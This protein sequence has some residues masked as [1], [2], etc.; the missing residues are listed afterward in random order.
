[1]KKILFTILG[2]LLLLIVTFLLY[3]QFSG[4]KKF[5]APY[6]EITASSDSAI[7]AR[8]KYLVYGPAH[9]A[10][11]HGDMSKKDAIDAGEIIALSGGWE[12]PIEP[13]VLRAPN[14]T[15]DKE[16]GIG[17]YTDQEV[18]R[19]LRHSVHP[20]GTI[21][22][23]LMPFQE[24]ADSDIQAVI[25]F[26]RSQAPVK[27]EV[28]RSEPTFLGKALMRAGLLKP[29]QA[30]NTPPATIKIDST[31]E[32]GAYL[33][34]SVANCVGCHTKRDLTTGGF[35]GEPF[36][37]GF[38]M[39]ADALSKGYS[40]ITPNLTP[41]ATGRMYD[42]NV[43]AF[44]TR[45]KGGRVVE[46]SPMPWGP[47][48]RMDSIDMIAIYKYLTSLPPVENEVPKYVFAPGEELPKE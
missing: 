2:A 46:T 20:D 21:N 9:C 40:F 28:A 30:S 3:I 34:N 15:T 24:M 29:L 38:I 18:A 36:A 11:C 19:V 6:P 16:T 1:M 8:G 10:D 37:G 5:D 41:D 25:S 33:A 22:F 32:Y 44:I 26:L 47:F 45:F 12:L 43:D 39:P 4:V 14:I 35:I 27:N 31:V 48:S 42:W 7:I 17:R 23:P 13:I